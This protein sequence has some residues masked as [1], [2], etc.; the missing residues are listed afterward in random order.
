[1]KKTSI[2][3]IFGGTGDLAHKKL[4]PALYNLWNQELIDDSF[5]IVSIG[6]RQK[7]IEQY[8]LE[9]FDAIYDHSRFDINETW[10]DMKPRIHYI[11]F[12]FSDDEG[13]KKLKDCLDELDRKCHNASERIFYMATAPE[14]FK[15]IS[16]KLKV[17]GFLE[18]DHDHRVIIE[19]PF[20]E[21]LPSAIEYNRRIT[22]A[23]G[24]G[25]VYRI[26]HYLGKEMIQNILA[27][28]FSNMV[29]EPL[30][31]N[32]FIDNVQITVAEDIGIEG[33]AKYYEKSGAMR[34]MVQNHLLQILALVAMEVPEHDTTDSIRK[35]KLEVLK[36]LRPFSDQMIRNDLVL[37][38]Y[39]NGEGTDEDKLGYRQEE[40]VDPESTTETFVA[41]RVN[42]DNDRWRG[43]PF[44]LRTGKRLNSK[45]AYVVIQFREAFQCRSIFSHHALRPNLLRIKIQPKE[46]VSIALN[47]KEPGTI[48]NIVP[49]EM[50][51]C[52]NCNI[53][54]KSPEAYEKLLLDVIKKDSTLFTRWEEI[55]QSWTFVDTITK[56]CV[57]K[58]EILEYYQANSEGPEGMR[59]LLERDD[60]RWWPMD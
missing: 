24:E 25:A 11:N 52:Q 13:Y 19:K 2:F 8:R 43:V 28:R 53:L 23:F 29:F 30:W 45:E 47:A 46:G 40:G 35:E 7:T 10:H 38:Q 20:G 44:Y 41:L 3:I 51:Y 33:R 55:E 60:R 18:D 34:D 17:H 26:D 50:D 32:D 48:Q 37:G 56:A 27:I 16:E 49:I 39:I 21:D 59:T 36:A 4:L 14:Y 6:R 54:N 15:I 42:V 22:D 1:M 31:T 12:D 9:V 5:R 58:K 57:D